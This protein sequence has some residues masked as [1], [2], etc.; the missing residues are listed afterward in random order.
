MN[1]S[2]KGDIALSVISLISGILGT[3]SFALVIWLRS[4]GLWFIISCVAFSV[5]GIVLSVVSL[6]KAERGKAISI[7]GMILSITALALLLILI[8]LIA[9]LFIFSLIL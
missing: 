4:Q 6:K 7:T 1:K 9:A 5:A 8:V 2:K 3:L